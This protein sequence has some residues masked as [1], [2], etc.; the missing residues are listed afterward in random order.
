MKDLTTLSMQKYY[1]RLY[2]KSP[3][4][5]KALSAKTV[6]NIHV[7]FSSALQR[8]VQL[9]ILRKNPAQNIELQKVKKYQ[10]GIYDSAELARLFPLLKDTDLECPIMILIMMGLRRGELLALTRT[11]YRLM[12][13]QLRNPLR[14]NH[15]YERLMHPTTLCSCWRRNA[16]TTK[17]A[18]RSLGGIFMIPIWLHLSPT[19][20]GS[21]LILLHRNSS[22]F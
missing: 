5:G 20:K 3:L 16:I 2:E 17:N 13:R 12:H 7:L 15:L 1:N 9:D 18:E 21:S 14:R 22:D 10:A 8:A 4:S 11:Q 6:R 19:G